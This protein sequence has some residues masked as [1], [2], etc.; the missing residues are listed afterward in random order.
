VRG[1][2]VIGLKR[3]GFPEETIRALKAAFKLVFRSDRPVCNALEQL[4]VDFPAVPEV[5]RLV[6][7]LEASGKGRLGRQGEAPGRS[8]TS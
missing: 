7:F 3:A 5:Q 2:N 8:H 4:K 6:R 1:L